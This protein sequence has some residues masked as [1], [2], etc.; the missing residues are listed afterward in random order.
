MDDDAV[1]V[2]DLLIAARARGVA[3][4]RDDR[5]GQLHRALGDFLDTHADAVRAARGCLPEASPLFGTYP[6]LDA[7]VSEL[8]YGGCAHWEG[9]AGQFLAFDLSVAWA[10]AWG[11]DRCLLPDGWGDAFVAALRAAGAVEREE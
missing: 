7:A 9:L 4:L 3:R 8:L 11:D 6:C 2:M 5:R 10:R 1:L